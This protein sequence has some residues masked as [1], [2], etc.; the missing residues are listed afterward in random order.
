MVW[1]WHI[2]VFYRKEYTTYRHTTYRWWIK[3]S[4]GIPILNPILQEIILQQRCIITWGSV[5]LTQSIPYGKPCCLEPY[6][7]R[8]PQIVLRHRS[9]CLEAFAS[10]HQYTTNTCSGCAYQAPFGSREIEGRGHIGIRRSELRRRLTTQ[11]KHLQLHRSA[12]VCDYSCRALHSH[13]GSASWY[14][15]SLLVSS[16]PTEFEFKSFFVD[17]FS[18]QMHSENG[19]SVDDEEKEKPDAMQNKERLNIILKMASQNIIKR[20]TG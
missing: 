14:F 13:R 15:L 1:F 3:T 5:Y 12:L 7:L 18:F 10:F 16:M 4:K 20:V 6:R 9:C 8:Q 19:A 11:S 2:G 17:L